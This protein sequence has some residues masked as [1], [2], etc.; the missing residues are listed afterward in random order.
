MINMCVCVSRSCNRNGKQITLDV[1]ILSFDNHG[2]WI[3]WTIELLESTPAIHHRLE[4]SDRKCLELSRKVGV[5]SDSRCTCEYT[6]LRTCVHTL[7]CIALH[8]IPLHPSILSYIFIYIYIYIRHMHIHIHIHVH[9]S[10]MYM[11]IH[12]YIYIYIHMHQHTHVN[13][14]IHLYLYIDTQKVNHLPRK[15]FNP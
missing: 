1:L 2:C 13:R 8:Y 4:F 15:S 5:S 10:Y 3:H 7:H 9:V 14:H 12:I 6:D 11:F